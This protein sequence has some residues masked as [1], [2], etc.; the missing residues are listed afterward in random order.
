MQF[1]SLNNSAVSCER[2]RLFSAELRLLVTENAGMPARVK[3]RME[4]V[5]TEVRQYTQISSNF[6]HN[7]QKNGVF[8][9][10]WVNNL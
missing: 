9:Y 3:L 7:S 1:F 6:P 8:S 2:S 5:F 4:A 10:E